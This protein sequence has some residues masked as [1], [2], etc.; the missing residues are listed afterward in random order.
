MFSLTASFIQHAPISSVVFA[1]PYKVEIF[2]CPGSDFT[3]GEGLSLG[4]GAELVVTC[5]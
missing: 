4:K 1:N 3:P 5:D 2:S